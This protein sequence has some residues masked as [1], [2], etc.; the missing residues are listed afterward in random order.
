M[1]GLTNKIALVGIDAGDL[2]FIRS[3]ISS[4]PN[5]RQTL[6]TGVVTTLHSTAHLL[7]G[8]VWP[9]FCTGTLPGDHGVFHHLQWDAVGMRMR[10]VN[11]DWLPFEP[12]WYDLQRRGLRTIAIDVPMTFRPRAA[13]GIEV[14]SWGSHDTLVPYAAQ[15]RELEK[16]IIRR[17]AKHPM[18]AEITVRKSEA[19]LRNIQARLVE[20][21]RRKTELCRWLADSQKWDFFIA[22]FGETH[23]GGHI[24]W[25]SDS[26]PEGALL[27][28]YRA[29]DR[30]VGEL[31]ATFRNHHARIVL[32]ALH[33][34]DTNVSQE[35]FVPRIMD[36][37]NK[38]FRGADT[39][40]DG[41]G[42][43]KGQRSIMRLLRE[44][45]P[46]PIQNFIGHAVPVGVRDAVVNRFIAGGHHWEST[47][48][49]AQLADYNGYIRLNLRGRETRGMLEPES[50]EYNRYIKHLSDGFRSF[51][52]EGG[53]EPLVGEIALA[54]TMFP[55]KRTFVL[56]DLIVSWSGVPP[57][58]RVVSSTLGTVNATLSTGRPGNHRSEGFCVFLDPHSAPP[59]LPTHIKDLAGSIVRMLAQTSTPTVS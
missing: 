34:M 40:S 56:P 38:R 37:I 11:D 25:P 44:R 27:D 20:G 49:F 48:G 2:N 54:G 1:S 36:R 46:D 33:G 4:L 29:V 30:A 32:F 6:Q 55:G 14:V 22:V 21:A 42:A 53:N 9:T 7:T 15:P 26:V 3:N 58:E 16:E 28:V 10:R 39:S 24:L 51:R 5:L 8:S 23:R 35:H 17:F 18:G 50:A 12:F 43:P 52:T 45:L 59:V 19:E 57:A 13:R 47:P 31:V 41:S